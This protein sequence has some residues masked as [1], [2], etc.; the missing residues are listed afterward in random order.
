M[1]AS[2]I[3]NALQ[4]NR[5]AEQYL[6]GVFAAD[7]LPAKEFPGAY[8]VNTD[9]SSQPG[10]HWVAFFTIEE[11]TECLDSFGGKSVVLFRT[12]CRVAQG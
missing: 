2:E 9:T 10:Q 7:R 3:E 8:I 12:H 11:G 4:S 5:F 6:V 1:N